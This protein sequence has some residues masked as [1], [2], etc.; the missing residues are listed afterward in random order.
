MTFQEDEQKIH[1]VSEDLDKIKGRSWSKFKG[2][3][4]NRLIIK[5]LTPHFTG[6]KIPEPNSFIEGYPLEFDL[7]ILKQNAEPINDYSNCY[8]KEDVKL[9]IEVKKHGFYFKKTE[10]KEKMRKYFAKQEAIGVPFLYITLKESK[11]L[12]ADA[13]AVLDNRCFTLGISPKPWL[14]DEWEKFVMA[15]KSN[16]H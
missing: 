14:N 1:Q 7:M 13:E 2:N 3:V 5:L 10:A 11:R 6:Y 9:V 15:I 16:L 8:K 12:K 4:V